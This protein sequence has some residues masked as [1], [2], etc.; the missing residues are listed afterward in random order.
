[1]SPNKLKKDMIGFIFDYSTKIPECDFE[2]IFIELFEKYIKEINDRILAIFPKMTFHTNLDHIGEQIFAIEIDKKDL[3]S[4]YKIQFCGMV[5]VIRKY[6]SELLKFTKTEG[7]YNNDNFCGNMEYFKYLIIDSLMLIADCEIQH[8]IHP[9]RQMDKQNIIS[10][11][12]SYISSLRMKIDLSAYSSLSSFN[13]SVFL[14]RQSIELKIKN[15]LGIN[16]ICDNTGRMIK[17]PGDKLME[18]FF[19]NSEIEFQ[20]IKKSI[21]RKIHNW[22]QYFVHGGYVLNIWQIDIAHDL[23]TPL[24]DTG[25]KNGSLS[26]YGGV[27][28]RKEYYETEFKTELGAFIDQKIFN[29]KREN[30]EKVFQVIKMPPEVLIY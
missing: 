11:N 19:S 14:I 26:I 1:M 3:D 5:I 21:V 9:V 29:S 23:L 24:F 18:F 15:A 8:G 25:E 30:G 6:Y 10:S 12:D 4:F 20:N 2:N 16:F 13:A 7:F 28:I 17:F 22:S 27:K